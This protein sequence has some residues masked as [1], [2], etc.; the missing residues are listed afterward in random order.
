MSSASL[1][2]LCED[3]ATLNKLYH[4]AHKN[5]SIFD[6]KNGKTYKTTAYKFELFLHNFLPFCK[7]GKFGVVT[8]DREDEFAPVK[9]A[10]DP[11]GKT[12]VK[13]SPMEAKFL[14]MKQHHIW[15]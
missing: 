15:I 10:N 13:D 4:T 6:T 2:K 8:V 14:L 3:T 9:N 12:I 5:L 1:L 11:D 7:K